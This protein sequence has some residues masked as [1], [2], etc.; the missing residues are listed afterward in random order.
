MFGFL[1]RVEKDA[2][3]GLKVSKWHISW[4][5]YRTS[6]QKRMYRMIGFCKV[7]SHSDM[8]SKNIEIIKFYVIMKK[9][10]QQTEGRF[11][12]EKSEQA[13]GGC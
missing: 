4:V 12:F 13:V 1:E 10:H 5:I 2:K 8:V 7:Y 3:M 9:I 6:V 11:C